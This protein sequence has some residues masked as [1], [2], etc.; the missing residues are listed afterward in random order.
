M[1]LLNVF[2]KNMMKGINLNLIEITKEISTNRENIVKY[3]RK[4]NQQVVNY[5]S[6]SY[7][8][9]SF[10][11]NEIYSILTNFIEVESLDFLLFINNQ[12][13]I[14]IK[15]KYKE[16]NEITVSLIYESLD[17]S[18]DSYECYFKQHSGIF[19]SKDYI[20]NTLVDKEINLSE[21]TVLFLEKLKEINFQNGK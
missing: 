13:R 5:I 3:E 6:N 18:K 16:N 17:R 1:S 12:N 8:Y 4:L 10:L 21:F 15:V 11:L 9:K 19:K 14:K 20:N 2:V 7:T